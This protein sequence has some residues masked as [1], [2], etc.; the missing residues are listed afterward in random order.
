MRR[1][2][3]AWLAAG[4][5]AFSACG[6]GAAAPTTSS[7]AAVED[8]RRAIAAE[9]AESAERALVDTR[10]DALGPE[11]IM[12]LVLD[13][14]DR[15][16]AATPDAAVAGAIIALGLDEAGEPVDERIVVE[17][18]SEGMATACPNDVL[19]AS[20]IDTLVVVGGDGDRSDVGTR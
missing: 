14:C 17:V 4:L 8:L 11:G 6:G 1:P 19:R 15:L 18:I 13:A 16:V 10:Y 12:D 20:G 9:Y 3:A 5:L 2:V 7:T